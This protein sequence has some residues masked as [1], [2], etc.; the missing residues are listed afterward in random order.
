MLPNSI[1]EGRRPL[2]RRVRVGRPVPAPGGGHES[3]ADL[4]RMVEGHF[5]A[6]RQVTL[7]RAKPSSDES[8]PTFPPFRRLFVFLVGKV[9][10]PK[11]EGTT[12]LTKHHS[13]GTVSFRPASC[14]RPSKSKLYLTNWLVAVPRSFPLTSERN[15][16][17][18]LRVFGPGSCSG[19]KQAS[20][21]RQRSSN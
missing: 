2:L 11:M 19:P 3:A 8:V 7:S 18:R 5:H 9:N 13:S 12:T 14:K 20:S 1:G 6:V 21:K 16:H 17:Q 4:D 15:M 10:V